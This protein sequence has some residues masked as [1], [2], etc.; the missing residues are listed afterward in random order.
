MLEKRLLETYLKKLKHGG[1]AIEY[2]DGD[3]QA[4]G[5][6]KPYVT[7]RLKNSEVV[8]KMMRSPSLGIGESYA[9]GLIDIDGP[10][11]DVVRL[12]IDN[13]SRLKP[14]LRTLASPKLHRNIRAQQKGY[15]AHHYDLGNDFYEKWL[16]K[17]M[18]YTCAYYRSPNDSLEKAQEQKIDYILKK[19]RLQKGQSLADLGCGW[20]TLL[21]TAAKKYGATG[22][23]VTLSE[24]QVKYANAA[25]KKAGVDKQIEFKLLNYQALP[26][27]GKQ[28]DRVVSVGM[29]E[30]VGQYNHHS[31]FETVDTLLKPGGVS[32]AHFISQQIELP[33]DAW[34]DKYIFP[35]GYLP[36][37]REITAL[38]P[39]YNF[40]L[41]DYENLRPH[42]TLTLHEWRKRFNKHQDW[43]EKKFDKKFYRMWDFW[44]A[45]SEGSFK[46]G[47][48]DLSHFVF[49]KGVTNELPLTR[50][51]W[52][53]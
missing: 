42:Y 2:W 51:D 22:I 28:Y 33:V 53:K 30:H 29:M 25:A 27:E 47:S 40:R 32:V 17:Q 8:R 19:L 15:I 46:Y 7:L 13:P 31:Y 38:L 16:D 48:I 52:Y 6:E 44:L 10:L 20:G 43:V 18:L 4:Y 35:G 11:T 23:G 3:K 50:E 37:V 21:I 34:I 41:I 45:C 14:L 24:E 49:T 12:A 26:Q 9:E 36:S 1:V 39:R 5:P